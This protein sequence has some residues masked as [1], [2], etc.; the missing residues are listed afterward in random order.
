MT[1]TPRFGVP[2]F[3]PTR[4]FDGPKGRSMAE[5]SQEY[6]E[7]LEGFVIDDL[8][9]VPERMLRQLRLLEPIVEGMEINQLQHSLQTATRAERAGAELDI[10]VAALVHDVGKTISNANH[11]AIAAEMVRPWLSDDAYWVIK[12]HQDFQGIHYFARMGLDP[13]M[14]LRHKDHPLYGLAEEFVDSWDNNAFD[15]GY[16]TLPLEH[17]EPMVREVFSRPARRA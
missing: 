11:P 14:R 8:N 3:D 2:G 6:I 4:R 12:V 9:Y 16:D 10:V 15:P 5:F 13:M 17:F 7:Y 1:A